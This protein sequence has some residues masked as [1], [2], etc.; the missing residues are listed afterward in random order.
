MKLPA[1]SVVLGFFLPTIINTS[2]F[3][4]LA[5]ANWVFNVFYN[6]TIDFLG[7]SLGALFLLGYIQLIYAVPVAIYLLIVGRYRTVTGLFAGCVPAL[8]FNAYLFSLKIII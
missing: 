2:I 8:L 7:L 5:G 6:L 3:I 1:D 4:F